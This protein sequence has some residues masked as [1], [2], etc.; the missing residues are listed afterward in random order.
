MADG[1]E[2]VGLVVSSDMEKRANTIVKLQFVLNDMLYY[3]D[4]CGWED[5]EWDFF[6]N[7]VAVA[8]KELPSGSWAKQ[9]FIGYSASMPETYKEGAL[10]ANMEEPAS[11]WMT[12]G[13]GFRGAFPVPPGLQPPPGPQKFPNNE[14]VIT[15]VQRLSD[16]IGV[17]RVQAVSNTYTQKNADNATN[18]LSAMTNQFRAG[19]YITDAEIAEGGLGLEG[20]VVEDI[21][22]TNPK[23]SKYF[24]EWLSPGDTWAPKFQSTATEMRALIQASLEEGEELSALDWDVELYMAFAGLAPSDSDKYE[25]ALNSLKMH[26]VSAAK[27]VK[28][29]P[30]YRIDTD[31]AFGT[32][33]MA[34]TI[35][36][37]YT[38]VEGKGL[39]DVY[40]PQ[41]TRK[42]LENQV[43]GLVGDWLRVNE[44]GVYAKSGEEALTAE[45]GE[46]AVYIIDAVT[47]YAMNSL[48]IKVNTTGKTFE[49]VFAEEITSGR[50]LG[51]KAALKNYYDTAYKTYQ[52][53]RQE[54]R[55]AGY[56]SEEEQAQVN[57]LADKMFSLSPD[58][59]KN[60]EDAIT[61]ALDARIEVYQHQQA[62]KYETMEE[63]LESPEFSD[64]VISRIGDKGAAGYL[65]DKDLDD[66]QKIT[67]KLLELTP[68]LFRNETEANNE[69]LRLFKTEA[70]FEQ[71]RYYKKETLDEYLDSE[72]FKEFIAPPKHPGYM[73]EED[74]AD[75]N[76][77]TVKLLDKFPTFFRNITEANTEAQLMW[78]SGAIYRQQQLFGMDSLDEYLDSDQFEDYALL[79]DIMPDP[80]TV[81]RPWELDEERARVGREFGLT[82]MEITNPLFQAALDSYIEQLQAYQSKTFLEGKRVGDVVTEVAELPQTLPTDAVAF[83]R[84]EFD[85]I[86]QPYDEMIKELGKFMTSVPREQ[87]RNV[88]G[89]YEKELTS[90][91]KALDMG[92]FGGNFEGYIRKTDLNVG[93]IAGILETQSIVEDYVARIE[94]EHNQLVKA[95]VLV[96]EFDKPE[97][98]LDK[99]TTVSNYIVEDE[100]SFYETAADQAA[101]TERT[102][103]INEQARRI[104]LAHQSAQ[105]EFT[106]ALRDW[107]FADIEIQDVAPYA[108]AM[109]AKYYTQVDPYAKTASLTDIERTI[110]SGEKP[111]VAPMMSFSQFV[112]QL[113]RGTFVDLIKPRRTKELFQ[114]PKL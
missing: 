16:E 60:R 108:S 56:L 62:S 87:W 17:S 55:V 19:G 105:I 78:S 77:I 71:Q 41:I 14:K 9:E 5:Y 49:E 109:W 66:I 46:E 23:I 30:A 28:D 1:K 34:E 57:N 7:T 75:V 93:I 110:K 76:K 12:K 6:L 92:E 38:Y 82:D 68:Q 111:E 39:L 50:L 15:I 67:K 98:M 69:A 107:G 64:Y 29:N 81:L 102:R 112:Q 27:K 21:K 48:D 85:K 45:E 4:A 86:R 88:L 94:R 31:I 97:T 35:S 40:F 22:A 47:R 95:G 80:V 65:S 72:Y 24:A 83:Y 44:G 114:L 99:W 90:Y 61:Y 51:N 79:Q 13:V 53:G 2:E 36:N 43:R 42:D 91:Q 8:A 58:L 18:F 54:T 73:S 106:Q 52:L 63:F 37:F 84:E 104:D 101:I 100:A 74:V 11:G 32:T 70:V 103:L 96:G 59:F 113:G 25:G 20:K 10:A 89:R 26:V 33:G 3:L